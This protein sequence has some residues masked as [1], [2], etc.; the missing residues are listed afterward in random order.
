M[1]FYSGPL[2]HFLSGVDSHRDNREFR[3]QRNGEQRVEMTAV[4]DHE[5]LREAQAAGLI[6]NLVEINAGDEQIGASVTHDARDEERRFGRYAIC[7]VCSD[8]WK[9]DDM[10]VALPLINICRS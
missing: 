2:M 10:A 9:A 3:L 4:A 5:T 6:A 7:R 8:H 1:Q